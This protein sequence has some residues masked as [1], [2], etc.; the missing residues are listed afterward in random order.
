[1]RNPPPP[2]TRFGPDARRATQRPGAKRF[3]VAQGMMPVIP[4]L[5]LPGVGGAPVIPPLAL[6]GA[7][8]AAPVGAVPVAPLAVP[9]VADNPTGVSIRRGRSL[10]LATNGFGLN[11]THDIEGQYAS[12]VATELVQVVLHP[13]P[14][15]KH[16]YTL[17]TNVGGGSFTDFHYFAPVDYDNVG[18]YV[19]YQIWFT[20]NWE[21]I[22]K[23][24]YK[25]TKR[26]F[27]KLLPSDDR[28]CSIVKEGWDVTITFRG[29]RYSSKPGKGHAAYHGKLRT[30]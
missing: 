27:E 30:A 5:A 13:T 26:I 15:R 21:V 7:G 11:V 4:R 3:A 22:P 19:S 29:V 8:G 9:V 2:P 10:F 12:V 1:M 20:Q 18:I 23:S 16:T 17:N 25:I 6:P 24:G 14:S 28:Y